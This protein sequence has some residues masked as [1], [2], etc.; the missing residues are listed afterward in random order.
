MGGAISSKTNLDNEKTIN[1]VYI[2]FE[3]KV[4]QTARKMRHLT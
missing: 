4:G 3:H 1:T 2:T